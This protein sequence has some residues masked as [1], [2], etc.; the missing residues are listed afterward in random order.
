MSAFRCIIIHALMGYMYMYMYMY[1]HYQFPSCHVSDHIIGFSVRI[2][3][4]SESLDFYFT[5][6]T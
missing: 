3:P 5:D 6:E 2:Q 4:Q 1:V